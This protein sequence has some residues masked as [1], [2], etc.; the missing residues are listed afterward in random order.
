MS[1][2][3]T[4]VAG[5]VLFVKL[6][7]TMA[8]G[9]TRVFADIVSNCGLSVVMCNFGMYILFSPFRLD[10]TLFMN[11]VQSDFHSAASSSKFHTLTECFYST[12]TPVG[13]LLLLN[14]VKCNLT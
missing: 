5:D 10:A 9:G 7:L 12:L 8:R 3:V 4:H 14:E 1:F 2:S 13:H 11:Y 6:T